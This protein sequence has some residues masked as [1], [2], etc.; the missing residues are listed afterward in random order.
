MINMN[1]NDEPTKS[2]EQK[3]LVQEK[4]GDDMDQDDETLFV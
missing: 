1:N 2:F 3:S 4:Y